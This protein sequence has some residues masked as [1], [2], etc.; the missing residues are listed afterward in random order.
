MIATKREENHFE[1]VVDIV[2]FP[3]I[4]LSVVSADN[5]LKMIEDG[6]ITPG[7]LSR[8][9]YYSKVFNTTFDKMSVKTINPYQGSDSN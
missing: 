7:G 1:I 5:L 3:C 9:G 4:L 6:K 8:I 2:D